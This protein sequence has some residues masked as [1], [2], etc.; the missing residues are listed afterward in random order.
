MGREVALKELKADKEV[1]FRRALLQ[2]AW[3][4]GLLEHPN[5]LPIYTIEQN[6]D[7]LTMILMKRSREKRGPI[8]L[9]TKKKQAELHIRISYRGIL[10][11]SCRYATHI[12]RPRPRFS[13]RY[14]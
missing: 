7:G 9:R 6:E 2:E 8:T 4:V 3:I 12:L 13:S 10:R 11:L 5:I 14:P 1:V